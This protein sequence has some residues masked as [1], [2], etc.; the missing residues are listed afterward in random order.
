MRTQEGLKHVML[1]KLL[2]KFV[3]TKDFS[4]V[5]LAIDDGMKI[6]AHKFFPFTNFQS[7]PKLNALTSPTSTFIVANINGIYYN[8]LILISVHQDYHGAVAPL[9]PHKIRLWSATKN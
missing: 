8:I 5:T 2:I 1:S 3:N 4:D 7:L 9:S 6:R